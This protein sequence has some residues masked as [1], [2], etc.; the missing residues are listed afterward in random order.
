MEQL[1]LPL[2]L[3]DPSKFHITLNFLGKVEEEK[4]P[5]LNRLINNCASSHQQFEL[6]PGYLDCMYKKH[7]DSYVY[8][9]LSGDLE[10]LKQIHKSLSLSLSDINIPQPERFFGH[11]TISRFKKADPVSI[12]RTMDQ[13]RD[14]EF[15]PLKTF[16]VDRLL[17]YESLLSDKGS[18]YR[19][20]GQFGLK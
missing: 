6:A 4:F 16:V 1:N 11:I 3:E 17:L 14:I 13:V 10:T 20:I 5:E 15:N 18:H 19:Q 9:G 12:K 7:A 2:R 8:L